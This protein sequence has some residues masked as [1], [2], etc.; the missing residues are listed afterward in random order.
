[1]LKKVKHS[2]TCTLNWIYSKVNRVYSEP[3]PIFHLSL[4]EI[5]LVVFYVILLTNQQ[6]NQPNNKITRVKTSPP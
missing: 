6:T 3:K 1:M 5:C 2:W 4:V